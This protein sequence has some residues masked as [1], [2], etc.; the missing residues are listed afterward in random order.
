[1]KEFNYFVQKFQI[2]FFPVTQSI[3]K[4]YVPLKVTLEQQ[5]QKLDEFD[6]LIAATALSHNLTLVTHNKKHF[7]RIP[8][9]K[10]T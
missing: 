4:R 6:L 10:M 3:I 5:G 8:D 9:L 1:M 7:S 2:E